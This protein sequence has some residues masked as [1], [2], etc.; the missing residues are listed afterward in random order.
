M[1]R[2]KQGTQTSMI[3]SKLIRKILE[4]VQVQTIQVPLAQTR[5]NENAA[6][7][8]SIQ[9]GTQALPILSLEQ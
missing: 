4:T 2:D 6:S 5:Q 7:R 3:L 1:I 9:L 8:S